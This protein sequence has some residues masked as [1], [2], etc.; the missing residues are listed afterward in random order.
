M[1]SMTGATGNT[2]ALN[3]LAMLCVVEGLQDENDLQPRRACQHSCGPITWSN[4]HRLHQATES[5]SLQLLGLRIT[6]VGFPS[7][8]PVSPR[9]TPAA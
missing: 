5:C 8:A 7:P 4:L 6:W 1:R 2:A 3:L 9:R